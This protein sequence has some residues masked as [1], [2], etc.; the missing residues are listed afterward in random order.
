MFQGYTGF[1]YFRKYDTNA[2]IEGFWIFQDSQYA[3]FLY[4]QELHKVL[5][6]MSI[7]GQSFTVFW[8]CLWF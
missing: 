2:I 7:P 4:M 8:T 1:T 3:R 5:N 6:V